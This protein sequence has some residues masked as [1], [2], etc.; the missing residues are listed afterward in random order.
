MTRVDQPPDG[1]FARFELIAWWDQQRLADARVL[2][3]GAGALGNEIVKN[4]ALLGVG[5]VLVVDPDRVERSNLSRSPLF[6]ERDCGAPK[7]EVLCAAAREIHPGLR[8]VPWVANVVHE[9]GLGAFRWADVVLCGLDNREARLAVNRAC[10][11]VDRPWIDG[12]IEVLA[13]MA[14]VFRPASGACYEC[15][16]SA[17]D[18]QLLARRR[19]CSLVPRDALPEAAVPTTPTT[20]SLVAAV[21]CTEALKILHGLKGLE[22]EGLQLDVSTYDSYRVAYVRDPLCCSHDPL[23]EFHDLPLVSAEAT[24]DDLA[25]AAAGILGGEVR[26]EA[27]RD[28]VSH[29][30]CGRCGAVRPV[31]KPLDAL[32]TA[33]VLCPDCGQES[34]PHLFRNFADVPEV[35]GRVL[36]QIGLPSWDVVIARRCDRRAGLVLAGDAPFETGGGPHGVDRGEASQA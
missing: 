21:Q 12:A 11:L 6:R 8:A 26:L 18:W 7:A 13:G 24:I 2:V 35:R 25:R 27:V 33:D 36:R 31:W 19:A 15:T 29:F 20:S 9:V 22:G 28:V 32:A 1:R 30:D 5:T 4:L 10:A 34:A 16:L 23:P 3:V 14:R 17:V